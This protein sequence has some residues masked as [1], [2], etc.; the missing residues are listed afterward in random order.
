MGSNKLVTF[1][2]IISL[3]TAIIGIV[4]QKEESPIEV[5]AKSTEFVEFVE[6]ISKN[7][8]ARGHTINKDLLI[9]RVTVV[10]KAEPYFENELD[11]PVGSVLRREVSSGEVIG[12]EDIIS[13]EDPRYLKYVQREGYVFYPLN[14]SNENLIKGYVST[15]DFVDVLAISSTKSNTS[16]DRY[17]YQSDEFNQ[18]RAT[19]L[20]HNVRIVSLNEELEKLKSENTKSNSVMQVVLEVSEQDVTR[21]MLAKRTLHIELMPASEQVHYPPSS[22]ESVIANYEDVT[23]LRGSHSLQTMGGL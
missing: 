17:R 6:W 1:L 15:G 3:C 2:M 5:A 13:P 20:L 14:V 23:E 8:M 12:E 9:K 21:I 22:M 16:D 11:I 19:T 4:S 10:E 18:L 7:E